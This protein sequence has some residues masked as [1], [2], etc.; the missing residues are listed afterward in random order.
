MSSQ[1]KV[2]PTNPRVEIAAEFLFGARLRRTPHDPRQHGQHHRRVGHKN[3]KAMHVAKEGEGKPAEMSH[4]RG[5]LYHEASLFAT[6]KGASAASTEL[7]EAVCTDHNR[8]ERDGRAPT[9]PSLASARSPAVG[10]RCGIGC[11][12]CQK[13]NAN[14]AQRISTPISSPAHAVQPPDRHA[15]AG[16]A[17]PSVPPR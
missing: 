14:D 6:E 15:A 13:L 4:R 3:G 7:S 12:A 16:I 9:H 8:R 5:R 10:A 2:N 11:T 17:A 1:F